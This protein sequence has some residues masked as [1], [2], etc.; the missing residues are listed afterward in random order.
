[1]RNSIL[2]FLLVVIEIAFGQHYFYCS[3]FS[4]KLQPVFLNGCAGQ[5]FPAEKSPLSVD[6]SDINRVRYHFRTYPPV[7]GELFSNIS[8]NRKE[9]APRE[10]LTECFVWLKEKPPSRLAANKTKL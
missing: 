3:I 9:K 10:S 5:F 7:Q 2:S 4:G 1:M 6:M 8:H